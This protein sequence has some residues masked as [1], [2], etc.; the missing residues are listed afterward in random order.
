MK[1]GFLSQYFEGVGAKRLS[2]VEARPERSN[3][4]ELN[5]V[6]VLHKLLGTEKLKDY[7]ARFIWL[8]AEDESFAEDSFVT[9]YDAREN[10]PSRSEYR[11]YFKANPVMEAAEEGDLLIVAKRPEGELLVIVAP[12]GSTTE[13]QLLWLFGLSLPDGSKIEYH[14]I[15][16]GSDKSIDYAARFIL[17]ELGIEIR[18]AE[19]DR[20]D[21]LITVFDKTF[22]T[23]A[24]FSVYARKTLPKEKYI[25]DGPDSALLAWMDWE[26]KLFRRLERLIVADRIE[27]GFVS[28]DGVDVDDFISFS[29]SVQNRRKSRAGFALE[30]HLEAIFKACRIRYSRG[31][32]TE[33]KAKPDFLFPGASEY[34][35]RDFPE[36]DLLML[37]VKSTCKERWRQVLSE[38]ARIRDKH[39]LTL[40]PGIS[41]NQTKEMTAN[42]LHLV[43]PRNLHETY[44][45]T[46]R[47]ILLD[48][49]SFI[50]L[51]EEKQ[52]LHGSHR[53]DFGT[54]V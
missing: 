6:K 10:H 18:D 12:E 11:L 37:G 8:S 35:N 4:H 27:K 3:Q 32:T 31:A 29:L 28:S 53:P 2:A 43:L 44:S 5:G 15:D 26:E 30:N 34:H 20:L 25:I 52:G 22:P 41:E 17:E 19:T 16:N 23:T 47:S 7:P 40:E 54:F 21:E 48:L 49:E 46:Q 45:A 42:R 24:E 14:N 36:T 38:A 51:I 1:E 50:D 39:L 33:N 9:W 13:N